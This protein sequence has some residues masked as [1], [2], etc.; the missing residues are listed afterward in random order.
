MQSAEK[1]LVM[2]PKGVRMKESPASLEANLQMHLSVAE[3]P[4]STHVF[5]DAA[6]TTSRFEDTLRARR[7]RIEAQEAIPVDQDLE[8]ATYT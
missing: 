7:S 1:M 5:G 6:D 4:L 3:Y 8:V 2:L